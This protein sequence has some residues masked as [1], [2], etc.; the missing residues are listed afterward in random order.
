VNGRVQKQSMCRAHTMQELPRG[1]RD[2]GQFLLAA[3]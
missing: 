2:A 1:S 3:P